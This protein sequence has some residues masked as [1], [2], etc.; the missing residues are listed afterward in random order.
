MRAF[1]GVD[2]SIMMRE[3]SPHCLGSEDSVC[4]W[5]RYHI[6]VE[7]FGVQGEDGADLGADMDRGIPSNP[8]RRLPCGVV[9]IRRGRARPR[10][11]FKNRMPSDPMPASIATAR[12][13]LTPSGAI[14]GK[15]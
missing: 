9:V 6:D 7:P 2:E 10:E 11:G 15:S 1:G 14:G 12:Y 3:Y 13:D 8:R 5:Y 4:I